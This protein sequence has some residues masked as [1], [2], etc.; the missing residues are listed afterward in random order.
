MKTRTGIA[1]M[2]GA[3]SVLML[4]ACASEPLE[5]SG[6]NSVTA[7]AGSETLT[8]MTYNV[9]NCDLGEQIDAIAADIEA[10]HPAVVC[11]QEI[12]KNVDRSGNR[13]VLRELAAAVGMNYEFYPTIHLQGGTYGLGIMSVYPLESCAMVPLETRREDEARVLAS[14]VIN[15]DGKQIKIYNTHL[16]F[17]DTDQRRQQWD[18]LNETLAGE[19]LPF[20]LMGDFNVAGMEE[21]SYLTGVECV[22]SASTHFETIVGDGDD[23]FRCIDNIFI[24]DGLTLLSGKMVDTSASDHRPL[25]AEIQL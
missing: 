18:F 10:Q 13:D 6:E 17:E 16:S 9:K 23:G 1:L 3:L 2:A 25:V 21:F 5:P 12:D 8:V 7:A 20:I 14:A 4:S 11:V 19:Q 24:S 15:V 22:N